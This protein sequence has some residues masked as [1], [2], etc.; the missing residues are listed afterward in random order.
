MGNTLP[1]EYSPEEPSLL[2]EQREGI[3]APIIPDKEAMLTSFRA[4]VPVIAI[5]KNY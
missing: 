2:P 3:L 1:L 4:T 5:D